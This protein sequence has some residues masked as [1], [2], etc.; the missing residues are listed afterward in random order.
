MADANVLRDARRSPVLLDRLL[1]DER[2]A[3]RCAE[4]DVNAFSVLYERHHQALYRY[5]RSIVRDPEDAADALQS[6]M[7]KALAGI[8][9]R[10]PRAPLRGWLFRI[11]HNESI[12]LLRRRSTTAAEA[13]DPER[14]LGPDVEATAERREALAQL[15]RD[16]HS[17]PERQ[18][19]ALLMREV[20]GLSHGEIAAAFGVSAGAVKQSIF[21]ARTA[22][23]DEAA[24]REMSC[25]TVQR[26][27]SDGDG[28]TARQRRIRGHLRQCEQC[29]GFQSALRARQADL[30]AVTPLLPAGSAAAILSGIVGGGGGGLVAT[31]LGGGASSALAKGAAVSAVTVTVGAGAL[32]VTVLPDRQDRDLGAALQSRDAEGAERDDGGGGG[33]VTVAEAAPRPPGGADGRH[34]GP[35]VGRDDEAEDRSGRR[36]DDDAPDNRSGRRDGGDDDADDHS[37]PDPGARAD[38]PDDHSGPGPGTGEREDRSGPGG[39]DRLSEDRSGPGGGG[40]DGVDDHSGPGGGGDTVALAEPD[41]SGPGGGDDTPDLLETDNSGP[42]G[43]GDDVVE[44]DNSGS[45]S[46]SSGS[47]SSGSGSSD[48]GV[49]GD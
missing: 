40:D 39:G 44:V 28:R 2:L 32:G 10:D 19:G 5:C 34:S 30:R 23:H 31:L 45:G 7:T 17:L 18:R 16:L 25:D 13:L 26:A 15:V 38:D 11:A 29:A 49:S 33:A 3:R 8:G 9:G 46:D 21:E 24:G 22:L 36:G 27:L 12:S 42:G 1:S 4:G 20:G 37:W 43:G 14:L 47:G 35:G 41:N 48:S 6:A